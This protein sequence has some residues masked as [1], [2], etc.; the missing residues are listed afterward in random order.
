MQADATMPCDVA[1]TGKPRCPTAAVAPL[2]S[3]TLA[4]ASQGLMRTKGKVARHA[5][6]LQGVTTQAFCH[7]LHTHVRP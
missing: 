5:T 1:N 2:L 4:S 3:K 6:V 7:S